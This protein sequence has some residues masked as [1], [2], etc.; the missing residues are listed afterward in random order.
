M[1]SSGLTKLVSP[2]SQSRTKIFSSVT[3]FALLF[4]SAI[5]FSPGK[6]QNDVIRGEFGV[7]YVL[8][9]EMLLY[10]FPTASVFCGDA[11][12]REVNCQKGGSST[13]VSNTG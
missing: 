7:E 8:G 6:V 2:P 1:L 3:I 13:Y 9:S 11:L 4:F 12:T 5:S 10:R